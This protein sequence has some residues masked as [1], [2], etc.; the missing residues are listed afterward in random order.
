[1]VVEA[2]AWDSRQGSTGNPE[3]NRKVAHVADLGGE[4]VEK[5]EKLR[6]LKCCQSAFNVLG[7]FLRGLRDKERVKWVRMFFFACKPRLEMNG[8][9]ERNRMPTCS[10]VQIYLHWHQDGFEFA[11]GLA[12]ADRKIGNA[13]RV[14]VQAL[15]TR[16][17]HDREIVQMLAQQPLCGRVKL[18]DDVVEPADRLLQRVNKVCMLF[19]LTRQEAD[20]KVFSGKLVVIGSRSKSRKGHAAG[21]SKRSDLQ[22]HIDGSF[23]HLQAHIVQRLGLSHQVNKL[24]RVVDTE[25]REAGKDVRLVLRRKINCVRRGLKNV[26]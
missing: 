18:C 14:P 9:L 10:F 16:Q 4:G 7:I 22:S 2:G 3:R 19:L 6:I 12:T 23:R 26:A 21:K 17:D 20:C 15:D 24:L 25:T 8:A 13:K 11:E 5:A 1:M